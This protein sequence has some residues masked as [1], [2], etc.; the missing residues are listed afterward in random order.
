MR[1]AS[2]QYYPYSGAIYAEQLA[3]PRWQKVKLVDLTAYRLDEY[4]P[5]QDVAKNHYCVGGYHQGGLYLAL[6]NNRPI[7]FR[8]PSTGQKITD[9]VF[10]LKR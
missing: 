3:N 7:Q 10:P 8:L 6:A 1:D 5:W 2:V 4:T 9:N